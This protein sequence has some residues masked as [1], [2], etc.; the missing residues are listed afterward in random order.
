MGVLIGSH[1]ASL[2]I[3]G[4]G[5]TTE[6]IWKYDDGNG[7][8]K[9]QTQ[10]VIIE[11]V[12]EPAADIDLVDITGQ[13]DV[14]LAPPSATDNCIGTVVATTTDPIHYDQIGTYTT[15]WVFDDG[16]GNTSS[17]TQT[18]IIGNSIESHGFSP[19]EDGINDTWTIDGIKTYPNCK[20]KV[21]NRSGHLVYEK[22]AYK[23]TWDG[24]SN[25][26]SNKK[27]MSGAY[28][29]IIEFNKNGL[30]PKTG[31]LYINY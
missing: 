10:L 8:I 30:R 29:F 22:V 7:N 20:V 11:D 28:Y 13:F 12:T 2:P 31:W 6:I 21:F 18:V 15:I 9:I 26:G 19:N 16:H 14:T 24:Y 1:N 27:M 3:S 17:Q 5:T 4:N 23:N 25:T